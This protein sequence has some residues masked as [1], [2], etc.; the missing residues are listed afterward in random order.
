MTLRVDYNLQCDTV[1][2]QC[3]LLV[4]PRVMFDIMIVFMEYI[5]QLENVK[6]I[7]SCF[8]FEEAQI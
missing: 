5:V 6:T 4:F 8:L 7:M 1:N 3:K 2:Q